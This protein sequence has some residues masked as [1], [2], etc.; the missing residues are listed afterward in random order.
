MKTAHFDCFAGASG[1]MII[2]SLL[3]AGLDLEILRTEIEKLAL[4]GVSL[5]SHKTVKNGISG[6]KFVVK[7]EPSS[8]RHHRNFKD[9]ESI[10]GS[11]ELSSYVQ[12]SSIRIFKALALAEAK[13]HG[14]SMEEVHFHE[15]GAIDSIV[16]VV[17]AC[18]GLE[19]LGID[20]IS[21][22]P[23]NVGSGTVNCAHGIFPVPAPATAELI[24]GK[25]VYTSGINGECLT[26][27]GAAILTTL[28]DE[29]GAMPIMNITN[30]GYGAG[31][32]DFDVP[33]LLRV[34]IGESAEKSGFESDQI[35]I[36]ETNIDDMNPQIY[37]HLMD[38]L[39]GS[40]ALDVYLTSVQMKKNRPGT[41][42]TV[43]C[44][45]DSENSINRILFEETTTIGLRIQTV[46]RKKL[47]RRFSKIS[48]IFGE[49]KCKVSEINGQPVSITPEYDDC[50]SIAVKKGVPLKSV[51]NEAR[52]AIS[53]SFQDENN[54]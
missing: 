29:F 8:C 30:T 15:V 23:M 14:V 44:Q 31:T 9:I 36:I 39:F 12:E 32:S 20:H 24:Q 33:N 13:I 21:V 3:D 34:F 47:R 46:R 17:G 37:D 35:L 28:A 53:R 16:D 5:Y 22:S 19:S 45:S 7:E 43:M 54:S 6:T 41:L 18:V 49:I 2:G 11:S 40:G 26:P 25:P 52:L 1:D 48:T 4:D 38:R 10:I 42:L 27:T 50:K 51:I